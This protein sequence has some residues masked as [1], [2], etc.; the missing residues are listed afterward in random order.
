MPDW[1]EK[2]MQRGHGRGRHADV[3]R[4]LTARDA[5]YDAIVQALRDREA[6]DRAARERRQRFWYKQSLENDPGVRSSASSTLSPARLYRFCTKVP[7]RAT[8]E[9]R[10][11]LDELR[12]TFPD[13]TVTF[14]HVTSGQQAVMLS[15]SAGAEPK[16]IGWVEQCIESDPKL[17]NVRYQGLAVQTDGG[18]MLVLRFRY[19]PTAVRMSTTH[20]ADESEMEFSEIRHALDVRPS[21]KGSSPRLVWVTRPEVE[22]ID[23]VR[24]R[25]YEAFYVRFKREVLAGLWKSLSRLLAG[26]PGSQWHLGSCYNVMREPDVT[27]FKIF[28]RTL[29]DSGRAVDIGSDRIYDAALATDILLL[30]LE[31]GILAD[32]ADIY[33]TLQDLNSADA[34]HLKEEFFTLI[35][36]FWASS[37]S[38]SSRYGSDLEAVVRMSLRALPMHAQ[39]PLLKQDWINLRQLLVD[40]YGEAGRKA[41]E[42]VGQ[43]V[44]RPR[45]GRSEWPFA[46]FPAGEVNVGLRFVYRQ[47]ACRESSR[48]LAEVQNVVLVAERLPKPAEICLSWVR[49]HD[50]ILAK[51]LLDESFRDALDTIREKRRT[52][53]DATRARLYEHLRANILHYQRAIWQEEDPQQRSMRYRKSGKKVPLE[54]RFELQSGRALSVDV[55][56][57]RLAATDVDGQFAAYSG[58][59]EANLDEVINPAGPIAYYGNYA[60]YL[61]RPEFGRADLFSM[62]HFFKSPYLRPNAD[63]GEPEVADPAEIQIR[64]HP[65]I[66]AASGEEVDEHRGAMLQNVLARVLEVAHAWKVILGADSSEKRIDLPKAAAAYELLPKGE[67]GIGLLSANGDPD[68]QGECAILFGA[69]ERMRDLFAGAEDARAIHRIIVP[70]QDD[71]LRPSPVATCEEPSGHTDRLVRVS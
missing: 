6:E 5:R 67:R 60:V 39:T 13:A 43:G 26:S 34:Y 66:E 71:G 4:N 52:P 21:H 18:T 12:K 22:T 24:S 20:D 47:S 15:G 49:R 53:L 38:L 25:D 10:A 69:G 55:F 9:A 14:P 1:F 59:R 19:P 30:Y 50:W 37:H 11:L 35:R 48:R 68:V 27:K 70:Q 42:L 45:V 62:L 17:C 23:A 44:Y 46:L 33:F 61:M 8:P 63:T 3:E 57:D 31:G 51:V 16:Q 2:L 41:P 29:D 28:Q 64:V 32:F 65:A 40:R 7:C 54:W 36:R 56:A 58:G